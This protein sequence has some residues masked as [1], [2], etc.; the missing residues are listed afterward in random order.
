MSEHDE[1]PRADTRASRDEEVPEGVDPETGV[2]EEQT[3]AEAADA[4]GSEDQIKKAERAVATFNKRIDAIFGDNAPPLQCPR[5]DG[6][7]RVWATGEEEPELVHPDNLVACE[8]CNGHGQ[9]LT[10]SKVKGNDTT[11]CQ[12]CNGTG[13]KIATPQPENVTPL[14]PRELTYQG[15]PQTPVMGW[16]QPDGTFV[17]LGT[18]QQGN[19]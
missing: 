17:P 16:Q 1:E 12:S 19:G 5:C 11:V 9:V 14:Q 15:N 10:G 7:G 8:R 3:P 4:D 18:P 6:L 2:I 13:W